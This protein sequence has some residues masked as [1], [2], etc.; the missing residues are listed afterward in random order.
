MQ[1]QATI[2]N[3]LSNV[4]NAYWDYVFAV[5]AVE[6]A[7]QSLD[8]RRA[9]RPGQPDARRGRHDGAD[10]R[11]PGAVAGGHRAPEA[12]RPRRRR[13]APRSWR[14]SGSSSAAR[15]IRTG[16]R[17]IDPV[18][19][20]D[21]RPEPIDVEAAVRRALERADR[22]RASRRRTS[23]ANDVTLKYLQQPDA[24]AGRPRAPATASSA[25]AARSSSPTGT[26]VNRT[27]TGTIPGGYG[28]ALSARCSAATTR[29]GPSR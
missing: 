4:R 28:D 7:R 21:F 3:T 24:A 13:G 29:A 16:T 14:S 8:A 25:S 12:R 22:P 2:T 11:R 26:G 27:V 17:T 15:R 20:P 19:R 23:Q 10:R 18:D 1:L 9:A 6:V 5:Q